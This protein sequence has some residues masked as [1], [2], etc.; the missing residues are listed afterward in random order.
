MG[1]GVWGS[2]APGTTQEALLTREPIQ[3]EIPF[4]WKGSLNLVVN[5]EWPQE[6]INDNNNNI[7]DNN[8][9]TDNSNNNDNNNNDDS[10]NND[11]NNNS[12]SSSELALVD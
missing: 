12:S 6:Y 4:F 7:N 9:I 11:N 10:N 1:W 3:N 2:I 8:N 5:D